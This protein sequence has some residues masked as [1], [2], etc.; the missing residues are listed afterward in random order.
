MIETNADNEALNKVVKNPP[1][2]N[3]LTKKN[4]ERKEKNERKMKDGKTT[5][6]YDVL[7]QAGKPS[8]SS[9]EFTHI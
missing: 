9:E 7:G 6:G 5:W 1:K 8:G 2:A 3:S 4:R